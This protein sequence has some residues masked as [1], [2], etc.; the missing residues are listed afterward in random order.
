M[1]SL[2]ALALV[3]TAAIAGGFGASP[4]GAVG[5]PRPCTLLKPAEITAAVDQPAGPGTDEL[6]PHVCQWSLIA[7]ADR[8][9]G[10][11]NAFVERGKRSKRDY[12]LGAKLNAEDVERVTGL[13]RKAFYAP[14]TGALWVLEDASTLYYVQANVYDVDATRITTGV[15]DALVELAKQAEAR[16]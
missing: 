11:V 10:T 2:A 14:S 8:A 5:I 4:A 7:T 6:V 3:A 13:G 15:K 9:A 16:I 12:A 1:R